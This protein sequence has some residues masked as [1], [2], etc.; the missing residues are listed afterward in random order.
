MAEAQRAESTKE[1]RK[2]TKDTRKEL[3]RV[4]HFIFLFFEAS[5]IFAVTTTKK[6]TIFMCVY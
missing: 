5:V 6:I 1:R 3:S 2:K 4:Q